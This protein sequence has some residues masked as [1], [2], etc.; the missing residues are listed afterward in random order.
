MLPGKFATSRPKVAR[1]WSYF[2]NRFGLDVV[3]ELEPKPGIEP[4]PS[5]LNDV[6]NIVEAQ[7]VK[8]LLMEPFYSRQAPDWLE[9]K[10]GIRIVQVANSVGGQPEATDYVA[11][12]DHVVRSCAAAAS[13]TTAA[14]P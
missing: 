7:K 12:I 3:A 8:F 5:H 14:A 11:M 13:G 1:S 6:L 10:T 4:S 2:V 9:K